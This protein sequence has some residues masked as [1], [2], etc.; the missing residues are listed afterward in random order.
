MTPELQVSL[1]G[2]AAAAPVL[3]N[4][5]TRRSSDALGLSGMILLIWVMGRVLWALYT[6][7]D[8]MALY[9]VIDAMAGATAFGAWATRR[10]AWKIALTWLFVLQ[11]AL[12]AAFWVAYPT[13]Q[14]GGILLRYLQLNNAIFACQLICVGAPGGV[15]LS[16]DVSGWL[17]RRA[18]FRDHARA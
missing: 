17:S 5:F 3:L 16:R 6:P 11:C 7:P 18:W 10:Q 1:W 15:Q 4:I 8:S 14:S 2:F 9:P 13:V 12:H